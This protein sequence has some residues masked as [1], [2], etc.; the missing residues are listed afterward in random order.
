MIGDEFIKVVV[1]LE[2]EKRGMA[3]FPGT[4]RI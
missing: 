2:F 3:C 4:G 1:I